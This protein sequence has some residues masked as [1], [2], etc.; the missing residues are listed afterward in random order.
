MPSL[1]T[2]TS[3][4]SAALSSDVQQKTVQLVLAALQKGT[5]IGGIREPLG[6]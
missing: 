4:S 1:E 5:I 3:P 2:Q 6:P